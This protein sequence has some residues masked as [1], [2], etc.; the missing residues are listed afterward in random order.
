MHRLFISYSHKDQFWFE[1]ISAHLAAFGRYVTIDPWSDARIRPGDHWEAS[2]MEAIDAAD[3]ALL[4]VSEHFLASRYIQDREMPALK[5]AEESKNILLM[6][7]I[8]S[9]C[10]WKLDAFLSGLE[11]RPKEKALSDADTP[12][13]QE[14][15]LYQCVNSI[16]DAILSVEE[17]RLHGAPVPPRVYDLGRIPSYSG[18]FLGRKKQLALLD[19]AWEDPRANVAGLVAW[20]GA[21]KTS[22]AKRWAISIREAGGRGASH[23]WGW[24]FYNQGTKVREQSSA[25]FFRRACDALSIDTS[26]KDQ[27][28]DLSKRLAEW[29]ARHRALII[30]DGVEPLQKGPGGAGDEFRIL[31]TVLRHFVVTLAQQNK[32]LALITSRYPLV[33]LDDYKDTPGRSNPYRVI[34]LEALTPEEGSQVLRS[35]GVKGEQAQLEEAVVGLDGHCLSISLLGGLLKQFRR[36][37]IEA[38]LENRNLFRSD[39]RDGAKHAWRVV[40]A[41]DREW[42]SRGGTEQPAAGD[43]LPRLIMLAVGLFDRPVP[44]SLIRNLPKTG[45]QGSLHE[46]GRASSARLSEAIAELRSGRLLVEASEEAGPADELECH[47]LIRE[48][49]GNKLRD[50]DEPGWRSANSAIYDKLVSMGP[51]RDDPSK[52]DLMV[53]YQ[54]IPHGV[55][56]G[57]A[58][59]AYSDLFRTK[60]RKGSSDYTVNQLGLWSDD[61]QAIAAFFRG[62]F[63]TPV[64][65]IGPSDVI[66]LQNESAFCLRSIGRLADAAARWDD[67]LAEAENQHLFDVAANIAGHLADVR[68][69]LGPLP[70]ALVAA[71]KAVRYSRLSKNGLQEALKRTSIAAA[72]HMMGDL[73]RAESQFREAERQEREFRPDV[74]YMRSRRAFHFCELLLE[75]NRFREVKSRALRLIRDE[76]EGVSNKLDLALPRLTLARLWLKQAQARRI[77]TIPRSLDIWHSVALYRAAKAAREASA[78]IEGSNDTIYNCILKL[79]MADIFVERREFTQAA[80]CLDEANRAIERGSVLLLDVDAKCAELRLLAA[81]LSDPGTRQN[82]DHVLYIKRRAVQ[83][84]DLVQRVSRKIGYTRR[85][86]EIQLLS[87][88]FHP[89]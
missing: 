33:D 51:T 37:R 28:I 59:D 78:Y 54:A 68:R 31:D 27:D 87:A 56:A 25:E 2:I 43:H 7:L 70:S 50:E 22:L 4:L 58:E 24:S 60:M 3:A 9:P 21:G 62:D 86:D 53:L 16:V 39:G 17:P 14:K 55:K 82:E 83:I 84:L 81:R 45:G 85:D 52:G 48:W 10:C 19:S 36:G 6:P 35:F 40:E 63:D 29:C 57:R 13:A 88:L 89:V 44:L 41:Y 75:Q 71:E 77:T 79:T 12:E 64:E 46:L 26:P 66:W 73:P 38:W 1:R 18:A 72:C 61:L 49:F 8:L 30:L 67:A 69:F 47:P 80:A 5:A 34:E 32:G 11:V 76:G 42:L 20:G 23:I 74:R 65:G 15:Q